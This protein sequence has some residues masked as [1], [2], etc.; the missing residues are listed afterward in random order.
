MDDWGSGTTAVRV[1]LGAGPFGGRLR[2]ER[3]A[4][5]ASYEATALDFAWAR[6]SLAATTAQSWYLAVETR[7]LVNLAGTG[8]RVYSQLLE[9][10][11]VRRAAGKVTDL[12]IAE[13]S[14]SLT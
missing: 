13:A 6:Q 1:L 9:L 10:V 12:D 11:N 8:C 2:A 5:Q 3:A 7:Q 14:A 4:S